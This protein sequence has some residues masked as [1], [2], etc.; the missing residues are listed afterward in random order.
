MAIKI[1]QIG[2]SDWAQDIEMPEDI[3]WYYTDI[4]HLPD[5]LEELKLEEL[6]KIKVKVGEEVPKINLRFNALFITSVVEEE[7]LDLL[8]GAVEAHAVF[9]KQGIPFSSKS[10]DGF[11]RKKV[12]KTL[13]FS[14]SKEEI[15]KFLQQNLFSGQ[16]GAKLKIPEIDVTPDFNGKVTYEGHVAVHFEGDFGEDFQPLYTYRYNLSKFSMALELWQE[17]IASDNCE[18][19]IEVTSFYAGSLHDVH[20]TL[21]ISGKALETPFI[22]DPEDGE[23]YYGVTIYAKGSGSLR[24]GPM[25]WRYSRKGLGQFVLGGRRFSDSKR[26]EFISYFN[27]GD[28]KPPLNVY[29]SGFRGAEGFEGFFMMKSM[30]APF[31]LIG[32]PRLEG[33]SFY[34]GT[35]EL[36][37]AIEDS[38]QESLD[39]LG[40]DS[41]QLILSGL[42]MGTFGA[43]YY[44]SHFNPSGIVVGKPFASLGNTAVGMKLKRPDE[45]ETMGDMLRNLTGGTTKENIKQLNHKFWNKFNQSDFPNTDF[46]IAFMENDDYDGTATKELVENLSDKNAHIYTKGYEGRHNDNSSAINKWFMRQYITILSERFGRSY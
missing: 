27:P 3:S 11:F 5:Y 33:G 44:A 25:H 46:A 39:Y 7:Q 18:V 40:F 34:G 22:L 24:F 21:F 17:Y 16:Y 4:D 32:D 14:G 29:F 20:R 43:L 19:A 13:P 15:V 23:G 30:K 36:E 6:S 37:A 28:M 8:N 35:P 41:S 10:F 26:Q 1:L 9:F 45:F 38:I 2:Q 42:S 12:A 31:M